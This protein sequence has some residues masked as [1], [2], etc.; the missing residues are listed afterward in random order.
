MSA[1]SLSDVSVPANAGASLPVDAD[2][3]RRFGGIARLYG[4]GAL[5]RLAR[6]RVCVVGVGG[7]G[8]WAVEALARS[9][10]GHLTLIDLDHVSESNINRQIQ[11]LEDTLGAA[12]VAT[13]AQRIAGI[14]PRCVVTTI[15]E[16][17]EADNVSTLLPAGRFDLV[18]DA[19]DSA[20]AKVALIAHCH[21]LAIPLI[22]VGS[23]G[24]QR[25]PT[26]I[27]VRDL[28]HTEQEPLLAKVRKR[29]RAEHGFTR[30]IKRRFGISAVFSEEPLHYPAPAAGEDA[31]GGRTGLH[32][33]GLGSSVA[34]TASFGLVAAASALEILL[35]EDEPSSSSPTASTSPSPRCSGQ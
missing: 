30:N 24:G 16:F 4:P 3:A 33:D 26:R 12:K 7:V 11:A 35:R 2:H 32:C 25:D 31:Q 9:A 18:I 19:I 29:L 27:R 34:V 21:A 10:V 1:T 22:T 6:A 28:A 5:A 13:L 20:A 8:S 14:N 23:A 17:V 15:E